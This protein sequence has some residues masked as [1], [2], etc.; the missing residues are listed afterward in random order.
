MPARLDYELD[1]DVSV[2]PLKASWV[3]WP[4]AFTLLA[5][6]GALADR[7]PVLSGLPGQVVFWA[8]V[9]CAVLAALAL[10][11]L[12]FD[13]RRIEVGPGRVR[14]RRGVLGVGIHRTIPRS[15][16]A[17]VEEET[18][19]SD[20][21]SYSVNIKLRSGKRYWAMAPASEKE[22]AAAL[23]SRLRQVLQIGRI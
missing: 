11:G 5:V 13:T 4:A 7:L 15:E 23:A 10:V 6:A 1:A 2:F 14:L 3:F 19:T 20:P 8:A 17:E 18:S 12:L 22:R 9:A 16:I 21:P